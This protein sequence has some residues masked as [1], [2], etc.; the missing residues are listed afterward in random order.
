M[1]EQRT[2]AVI[3]RYLDELQGDAAAEPIIRNLLERSAH[4]L[5]LLC[6]ALLHRSYPRLTHPP[7]N[8]ETDELVSGVVSGLITALQK[9]HPQTVGCQK[10]V[11]NKQIPVVHN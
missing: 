8:L 10:V 3:Q 1:N 6:A 5:R 9:V 2:T 11:Q 4:R 7:L